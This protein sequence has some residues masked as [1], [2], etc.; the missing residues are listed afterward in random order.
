MW[1]CLNWGREESEEEKPFILGWDIGHRFYKVKKRLVK[2]CY[3]YYIIHWLLPTEGMKLL[4]WVGKM[5]DV[6]V[7]WLLLVG[8]SRLF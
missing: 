5:P 3:L 8:Y 7:F 2:L 4:S 6:G 1:N